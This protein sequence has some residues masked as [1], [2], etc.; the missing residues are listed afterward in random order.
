MNNRLNG[1]KS[2]WIDT[3]LEFY[4]DRSSSL[5]HGKRYDEF[6]WFQEMMTRDFWQNASGE[7]LFTMSEMPVP[8][9]SDVID[10]AKII[11]GFSEMHE[12]YRIKIDN[13]SFGDDSDDNSEGTEA[14]NLFMLFQEYMSQKPGNIRAGI[15]IK[16]IFK[17]W[18]MQPELYSSIDDDRIVHAIEQ[19]GFMKKY[20]ESK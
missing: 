8:P 11:L 10:F 17:D 7:G 2:D 13:M 19:H 18:A 16:D 12:V 6:S 14:E 5:Y 4:R 1:K 3:T 9:L 15:V 20:E